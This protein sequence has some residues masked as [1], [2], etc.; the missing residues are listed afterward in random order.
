L[1]GKR[2]K[3]EPHIQILVHTNVQGIYTSNLSECWV[4]LGLNAIN[5]N[6]KG[7]GKEQEEE[8]AAAGNAHFDNI[9]DKIMWQQRALRNKRG[10]W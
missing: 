8:V 10:E 3:H 9:S 2:L 4:G 5:N 6:D 7:G 1:V